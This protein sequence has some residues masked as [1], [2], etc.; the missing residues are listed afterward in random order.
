M[1]LTRSVSVS[2]PQGTYVRSADLSGDAVPSQELH[3]VGHELSH[4]WAR[5]RSALEP[6]RWFNEH[7]LL[8]GLGRRKDPRVATT[9]RL[10]NRQGCVAGTR[11]QG[12]SPCRLQ[13]LANRA[14][15][16]FR[17]WSPHVRTPTIRAQDLPQPS[18]IRRVARPANAHSRVCS[19]DSTTMV[20]A[21]A[22]MLEV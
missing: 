5:P 1:A 8:N 12:R 2:Q 7:P 20:G 19:A 10:A 4:G 6:G 17:H 16:P 3:A 22:L 15:E 14:A 21:A 11:G 9:I 13:G 18:S